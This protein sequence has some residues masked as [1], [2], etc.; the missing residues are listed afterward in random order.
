MSRRA[1]TTTTTKSKAWS[2]GYSQARKLWQNGD[3]PCGDLDDVISNFWPDVYDKVFQECEERYSLWGDREDDCKEGAETFVYKQVADC[4]STKD[5]RNLGELAAGDIAVVFCKS[6]N[7][8]GAQDVPTFF[9]PTCAKIA[10]NRC[11]DNIIDQ[12]ESIIEFNGDCDGLTD[13][14][15]LTDDQLDMLDDECIEEVDDLVEDAELP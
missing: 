11:K 12:V 3:Y 7:N 10:K 9:P 1:T 13:V 5:C 8:K 6:D 2:W 15:D 14:L 4:V